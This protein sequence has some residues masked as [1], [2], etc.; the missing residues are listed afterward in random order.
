MFETG[1]MIDATARVS[2]AGSHASAVALDAVPGVGAFQAVSQGPALRG[3]GTS[4]STAPVLPVTS[5]LASVLPAG[6]R[7]GSTV[8]VSGSVSLLLAVLAAASAEGAWCALVGM[9]PISAEAA[10]D[11]GVELSRLPMVP[12]PGE[13]WVVVVGALLDAMDLVVAR[14]P[15]RL[16]DG[17]IR[18]IAARARSRGAVFLPFSTGGAHWPHADVRLSIEGGSWSG[19]G[20]GY[21]RLRQRE[22]TVTVQGRGTSAHQRSATL[23]LPTAAGGVEE[24]LAQP[25]AVVV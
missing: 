7:R 13:S 3:Q 2:K 11:F 4:R 15:A 22:V 20:L 18:R 25:L 10:R 17:D 19:I 9:P 23:W 14:A 16:A 21:G 8:S 1:R 5:A 24:F 12:C 6:L